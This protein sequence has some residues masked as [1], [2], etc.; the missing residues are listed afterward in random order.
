MSKK[1]RFHHLGTDLAFLA[2]DAAVIVAA[3]ALLTNKNNTKN[4]KSQREA[5]SA[6]DQTFTTLQ[7]LK[8]VD[9]TTRT[10]M[11]AILEE[12]MKVNPELRIFFTKERLQVLMT[13]K[14]GE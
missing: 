14:V 9:E 3:M 8:E 7:R 13:P 2:A 12:K 4:E 6:V 10:R 11:L 1:G 5:H